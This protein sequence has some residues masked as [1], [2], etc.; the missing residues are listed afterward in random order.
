MKLIYPS[1]QLAFAISNIVH[2]NPLSL[3][4]PNKGLEPA[5][6]VSFIVCPPDS[7]E[8]HTYMDD[9]KTIAACC[10]YLKSPI[11]A[12]DT[13]Y[14]NKKDPDWPNGLIICSNGFQIADPHRQCRGGGIL[15]SNHPRTCLIPEFAKEFHAI[16][17]GRS[18]PPWKHQPR[19]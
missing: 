12:I 10:P 1:M 16:S 6:Y 14:L 4:D 8:F 19:A 5:D 3:N 17:D 7:T 13:G 18:C 9:C 2:A 11:G 15:Y